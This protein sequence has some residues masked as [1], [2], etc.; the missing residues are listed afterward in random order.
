MADGETTLHL[1]L[2]LSELAL[3]HLRERAEKLGLAVDAVVSGLV[4]QQMFDYDAYHWAGQ[5]PRTTPAPP[6]D[7]SEVTFGLDEV[8]TEFRAE[9][10]RRL[11]AKG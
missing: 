6:H 2:T 8:M 3:K 4:E 7:P 10:E 11:A 9:L 5:D 1:Q